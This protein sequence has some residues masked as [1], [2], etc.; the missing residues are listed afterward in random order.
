MFWRCCGNRWR[1]VSYTYN[2][3]GVINLNAFGVL[4][5]RLMVS[6]GSGRGR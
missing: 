1:M 5:S 4:A 6:A 3:A 2:L